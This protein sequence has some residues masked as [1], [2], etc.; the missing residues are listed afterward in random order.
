MQGQPPPPPQQQQQQQPLQGYPGGYP[1]PSSS[2]ATPAY[3]IPPPSNSGSLDLSNIKPV[4]SGSVSFNDAVAKARG[5]AAERGVSYDIGRA[6]G[7]KIFPS[8]R[9]RTISHLYFA[10]TMLTVDLL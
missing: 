4:N 3:H 5:I 8:P 7:S 10:G 6:N 1:A 9:I 2:A